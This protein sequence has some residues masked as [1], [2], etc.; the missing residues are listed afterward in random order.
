MNFRFKLGIVELSLRF[1]WPT[2]ARNVGIRKYQLANGELG[3]ATERR[4]WR[5]IQTGRDAFHCVRSSSPQA[6][7]RLRPQNASCPWSDDPARSWSWECGRAR[8]YQRT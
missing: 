4:L 6:V 2:G 1:S 7:N 5:L 3:P 8:P